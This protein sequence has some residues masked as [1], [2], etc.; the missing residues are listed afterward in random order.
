MNCADVD[1]KGY[2]VEE[3]PAGERRVVEEH[4]LGCDSCQAEMERLRTTHAALLAL[5]E[6]EVPRRIAFVSDKVMEPTW[7]QRFW[8]SGPR[9]G[10]AAAAML[11][12]A[13]VVHG[14]SRPV[15][16]PAASQTALDQRVKA[17]EAAFD[18]RLQK[19]VE[20]RVAA[21][22]DA[23]LSARETEYQNRLASTVADAERRVR[24]QNR[25][26]LLAVRDA[27][28][29]LRKQNNINYTVAAN[30]RGM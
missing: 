17:M 11:S 22:V 7:W 10:F 9:L 15:Q 16:A 12:L 30:F 26:E 2:F 5:R 13:I 29:I 20:M 8:H 19:E 3:L 24:E 25:Q 6:E 23:R 14:V 27:Y 18:Q 1:L 28:E 4:L 21:A